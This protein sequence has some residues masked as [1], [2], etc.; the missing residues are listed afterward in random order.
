[1]QG[2]G[3]GFD[4]IPYST[5]I[6]SSVC[7]GS[8]STA[9][10]ADPRCYASGGFTKYID[11]F[12][13][14]VFGTAT[15]TEVDLRQ[16]ASAL[17]QVFDNNQDGV[18]DNKAAAACAALKCALYL[19]NT[20]DS[21]KPEAA[22]KTALTTAGHLAVVEVPDAKIFHSGQS[23]SPTG[24]ESREVRAALTLASYAY[25]CAYPTDFGIMAG[26]SSSTSTLSKAFDRARTNLATPDRTDQAN[27]AWAAL[28]PS[29]TNEWL[30]TTDDS[31]DYEC[32]LRHYFYL[33]ID[34]KMDYDSGDSDRIALLKDT[35]KTNYPFYWAQ[36]KAATGEVTGNEGFFKVLESADYYSSSSTG[37]RHFFHTTAIAASSWA[38]L[39]NKVVANK[40][41]TYSGATPNTANGRP[42]GMQ[43]TKDF[44]T[45]YELTTKTDK[46]TCKVYVAPAKAKDVVAVIAASVAVAKRTAG[47]VNNSIISGGAS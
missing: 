16:A 9:S 46:S 19:V 1:M 35:G 22:D 39:P 30:R 8:P 26:S 2:P 36:D 24:L 44:P 34:Q 43:E 32:Y 15:V 25:S 12:G 10:T 3:T 6:S 18:P 28:S 29:P 41:V 23:A 17:A 40:V 31:C 7:T 14:T 33:I 21:P 37:D 4:N 47:A 38:H 11:V 5:D 20:G 42:K 45:T 27:S 13:S